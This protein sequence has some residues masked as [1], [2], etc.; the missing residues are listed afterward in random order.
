VTINLLK[1]VLVVVNSLTLA[2]ALEILGKLSKVYL[3]RGVYL[4][5]Q[6]ATLIKF[7]DLGDDCFNLIRPINRLDNIWFHG[8]PPGNEEW[9]CGPVCQY[10]ADVILHEIMERGEKQVADIVHS[11][12]ALGAP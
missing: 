6:T 12:V 11:V 7:E 3:F 1:S 2:E 8:G 5:N 10:V 4:D 9:I